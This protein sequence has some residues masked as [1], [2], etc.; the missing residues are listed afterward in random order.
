MNIQRESSTD[1]TSIFEFPG[2]KIQYTPF[3]LFEIKYMLL[4]IE[5]NFTSKTLIDCE[6]KLKIKILYDLQ[7]IKLDIAEM[8]IDKKDVS[9]SVEIKNVLVDL[10]KDK[11]II[12]LKKIQ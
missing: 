2:S 10:E 4:K 7:E 1:T 12:Q 5:P 8:K 6:Q 11:L 3:H 9:S